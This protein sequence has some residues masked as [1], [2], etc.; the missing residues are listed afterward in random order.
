MDSDYITAI[1]TSIGVIFTLLGIYI[2]LEQYKKENRFKKATYFSEMRNRFKNNQVFNEIREKVNTRQNLDQFTQTQLYDYA[3]FF[4]ELQIAINSKFI[5]PK[6]V[7]YLFGHYILD[8][9]DNNDGRVE[10]GAPLWVALN[11]LV[12]TMREIKNQQLNNV[13]LKF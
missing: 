10:I 3:G 1:A 5:E 13:E 4:E 12:N 9:A 11:E 7:Y 6:M 2:A 8:F